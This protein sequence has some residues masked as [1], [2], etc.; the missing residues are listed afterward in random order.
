MNENRNVMDVVVLAGEILLHNG[1]EIFRVQETIIKIAEA[2]NVASFD[3]YVISNGIF[4]SIS[5][6]GK[7]YSTGIKHVPLSPVHLG[8]VIAVNDLSRKIVQGQYT[9]EEAYNRLKE[10]TQMPYKEEWFQIV[11]SGVG[12]GCFCYLL[13]GSI[14]DSSISFLT[15]IIL[16]IFVLSVSGKKLSK[17]IVHIF[18]SG[19]VTLC[20]L[21]F[22]YLGMGT[23]L[24]KIIIGSIIPLLPGV[25]LTTSIRDFLNSDYLSGTIRLIDTLLIAF[26]IAIGVGGMLKIWSILFLGGVIG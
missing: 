10:I 21:V 24:D 13:G 6:K 2:Y 19:L 1:A 26:S 7:Y 5:E 23:E 17:I 16:Y 12:S 8:R 18:G 4:V 14:S 20:G 9:V 25:P 3:V 22:F 15:G 11:C